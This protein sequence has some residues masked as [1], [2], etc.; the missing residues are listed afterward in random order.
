MWFLDPAKSSDKVTVQN[1]RRKVLRELKK[2]KIAWPEL[3]YRIER[4]TRGEKKRNADPESVRAADRAASS[5]S[6]HQL[7]PQR[8]AA[9]LS[10][11]WA[12]PG[13]RGSCRQ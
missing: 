5:P 6:T 7:N 10:G 13:I 3:N 11:W 8:G 2:I 1:F 9:A 12:S 4:G